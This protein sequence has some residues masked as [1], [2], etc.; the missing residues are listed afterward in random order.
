MQIANS[1]TD[2]SEAKETSLDGGIVYSSMTRLNGKKYACS[3]T[4]AYQNKS[5]IEI[6]RNPQIIP[7][8]S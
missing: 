6:S 1:W 3:H 2:N 5:N 7:A 4:D 8:S